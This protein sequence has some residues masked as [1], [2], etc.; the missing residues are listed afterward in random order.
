MLFIFNYSMHQLRLSWRNIVFELSPLIHTY[1][2]MFIH[3]FICSFIHNSVHSLTVCMT[4]SIIPLII[5]SDFNINVDKSLL[6][7][8]S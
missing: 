4:L 8:A 2:C 1:I 3:S 7:L 6:T 5:I